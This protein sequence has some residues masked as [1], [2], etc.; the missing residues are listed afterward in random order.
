MRERERQQES[1]RARE[2]ERD[3]ERE[4]K[5]STNHI[6]YALIVP[7]N[8]KH[9]SY[10]CH[11]TGPKKYSNRTPKSFQMAPKSTPK[12]TLRVAQ[13]RPKSIPEP[14]LLITDK[15]GAKGS[16]K[17]ARSDPKNHE[18]SNKST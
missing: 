14:G 5:P 4:V 10:N 2:R 13:G 16:Q 12:V 1:K 18:I 7:S 17:G 3:R 9:L 11:S 15:K 6:K 8:L